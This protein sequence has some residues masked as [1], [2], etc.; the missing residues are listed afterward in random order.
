MEGSFRPPLDIQGY[1]DRLGP[2]ST[3]LSRSESAEEREWGVTAR[4]FLWGTGEAECSTCTDLVPSP[5]VIFD[6]NGYYRSLGF[7]FPYMGI[8]RKMLRMAYFLKNGHVN[9]RMTMIMKV[10]LDKAEKRK[11]DLTRLGDRYID[12]AWTDYFNREAQA[13]ARSRNLRYG[14]ETTKRDVLS[15]W[16]LDSDTPE[17]PA[18][19]SVGGVVHD[20]DYPTDEGSPEP[21]GWSYYLW[22][23]RSTDT[24]TLE[25]WQGKLLREC[26]LREARIRFCVG[27]S[28]RRTPARWT[29]G[30]IGQHRVIFLR[31]DVEPTDELAAYA[32]SAVLREHNDEVRKVEA[33]H[34]EPL[35]PPRRTAG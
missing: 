4:P 14:S 25:L 2:E 32:V 27:F 9:V 28:G 29:T 34:G 33:I 20:P 11:Y 23:S 30:V 24:A 3:V 16:G 12:Q 5:H 13:E 8:T 19:D 1:V 21:W 10:L 6:V 22:G 7:E 31:E 35:L 15:E 17:D 18:L 26:I